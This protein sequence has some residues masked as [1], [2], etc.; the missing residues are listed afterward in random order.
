MLGLLHPTSGNIMVDNYD[1]KTYQNDWQRHIGYVPQTIF[2]TDSSIRKN[3]AFGVN[4]NEIDDSRIK[5]IIKDVQ[6]SDY[7]INLP[8]GIDTLV[9]ER[10]VRLSGGQKQR[11]GIAR[12]LYNNPEILVLD[13]ATSSLDNATER[14]IM[15]T[16]NKLQKD[17]T[18]VIV[19]HRLSTVKDCD[20]LY[21]FSNGRLVEEGCPSKLLKSNI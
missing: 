2:L 20:K 18:I 16:V 7:I 12:A 4:N 9:G 6:L 11:I 14:R 8:D 19:A 21:R 10:G 1:I 13:E 17:K 15:N 3:I 5:A